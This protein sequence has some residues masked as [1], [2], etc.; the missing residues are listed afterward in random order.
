MSKYVDRSYGVEI[1]EKQSLPID[2]KESIRVLSK[3]REAPWN[4][5][6]STK[7]LP[8][9]SHEVRDGHWNSV[10]KDAP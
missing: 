9:S 8:R 2:L 3:L 1:D 6:E 5:A 4:Y 7:E 10:S